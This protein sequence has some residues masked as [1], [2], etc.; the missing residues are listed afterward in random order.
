MPRAEVN[1]EKLEELRE[2]LFLYDR[3]DIRGMVPHSRVASVLS[4]ADVFLNTALTEAFCI[5]IVE[6]ARLGLLVVS[7]DVGGVPEVLPDH[8]V[9]LAKPEV[10]DICQT[11]MKL[12]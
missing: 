2:R 5:A 3:V 4:E 9:T 6:A 12:F 11:L 1:L 8:L 10:S 7:T